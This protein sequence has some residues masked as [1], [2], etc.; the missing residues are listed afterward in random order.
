MISLET[1][2]PVVSVE[3]SLDGLGT[4]PIDMFFKAFVR[5]KFEAELSSRSTMLQ[6][7]A[8]LTLDLVAYSRL[9]KSKLW[10]L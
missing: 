4:Q 3:F 7:E 8:A 5:E 1:P 9:I 6:T 10:L 2:N